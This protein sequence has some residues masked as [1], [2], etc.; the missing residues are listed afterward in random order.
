M[1]NY[2]R[3]QVMQVI[4]SV[5]DKT[6]PSESG[7][8]EN[9][10]VELEGLA[11]IID[12]MHAEIIASGGH[13]V[14]GK[15][16]PTATDELDA[17][18]ITTEEASASIMDSCDVIQA[19]V[20]NIDD[21]TKNKVF[22]Q[23]TKIFE[24]C[25]FQDITGQRISKVVSTLREIESSVDGLLGLF[26]PTTSGVLPKDVETRTE[27]EQLL[28]GPQLEGKGVSQEDIDKLLA[29]FD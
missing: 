15:H 27:D 23:T 3:D 8:L 12:D 6:S 26:G 4:S 21:E 13:N 7:A 2:S 17:V 16:V 19:V 18:I 5:M 25:S 22:E 9:I 11:K 10:H 29:E 24:A 14:G 1:S 28:N 20:E